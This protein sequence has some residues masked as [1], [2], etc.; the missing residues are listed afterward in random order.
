MRYLSSRSGENG[1][2]MERQLDGAVPNDLPHHFIP[3]TR[4]DRRPVVKRRGHRGAQDDGE[5][6]VAPSLAET[7]G[8][9]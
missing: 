4:D 5:S 9:Y 7:E 2:G 8:A 3:L 6:G 1:R